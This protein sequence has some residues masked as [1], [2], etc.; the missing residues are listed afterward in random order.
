MTAPALTPAPT[1]AGHTTRDVRCHADSSVATHALVHGTCLV[2]LCAP[3]AERGR[4]A[5]KAL[6]AEARATCKAC[7]K[8]DFPVSD[9]SIQPI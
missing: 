4:R 6:S 7:G 8:R 2:P 3:H 5:F 9:L 1:D